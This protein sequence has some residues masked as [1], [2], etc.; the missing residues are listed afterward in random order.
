M[1]I[2]SIL[3][4]HEKEIKV[5]IVHLKMRHLQ[6]LT[7]LRMIPKV[8]KSVAFGNCGIVPC[9]FALDTCEDW[10]RGL[11]PQTVANLYCSAYI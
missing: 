8:T 6:P 2:L 9:A 11:Q 3:R 1:P 7:V 10:A 5:T 4:L